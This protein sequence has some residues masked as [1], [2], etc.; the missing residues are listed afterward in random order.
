[1][2]TSLCSPAETVDLMSF[3]RALEA[4]SFQL[5]SA[6]FHHSIYMIFLK[7]QRECWVHVYTDGD[8]KLARHI[9]KASFNPYWCGWSMH[10]AVTLQC[11]M[12]WARYYICKGLRSVFRIFF[13]SIYYQMYL[14]KWETSSILAKGGAEVSIKARGRS[15]T[16]Q[17]VPVA[18]V[19]HGAEVGRSL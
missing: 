2:H 11:L 3:R 13:G 9:Q 1:M 8:P 15:P 4:G 5:Y 16:R 17:R 14:F 10:P 12:G 18:P 7:T 19:A 6:L